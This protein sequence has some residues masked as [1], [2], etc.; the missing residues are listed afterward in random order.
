MVAAGDPPPEASGP[1]GV[2]AARASR[3]LGQQYADITKLRQ[4]AAQHDRT[5]AKAQQRASRLNTRIEKL[6][7]QATLLREKE[8][9]VLG[10]VPNLEQQIKQYQ[11]DIEA[12]TRRAGG[13]PVSSDVT[14]LQYR[15]RKVQQ[16]VVDRQQKARSLELAAATKTQKTAEL[17]VRVSRFLETSRLSEQEAATYRKRADR[18]QLVHEQEAGTS[19]PPVAP[20]AGSPPEPPSGTP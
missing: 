15:L 9:R 12:G 2:L 1:T 3:W 4:I 5:A 20:S 18:L 11:R 7:H 17:K 13:G 14:G 16:K 19:A 8:Q 10:E 6:R